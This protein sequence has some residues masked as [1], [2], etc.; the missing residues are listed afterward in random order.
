MLIANTAE[1]LQNNKRDA[2]TTAEKVEQYFLSFIAF[3][4]CISNIIR[5]QGLRIKEKDKHTILKRR[6]GIL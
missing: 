5:Y 2:S 3:I 1:V 6:K 4:Y